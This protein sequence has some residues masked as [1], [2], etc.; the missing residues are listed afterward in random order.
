MPA[1]AQSAGAA[2]W[3]SAAGGAEGPGQPR[4]RAGPSP[5]PELPPRPPQGMG[6][7]APRPRP[8]ESSPEQVSAGGAR[9]VSGRCPP[10]ALPPQGS[11]SILS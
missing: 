11:A 6:A 2:G 4:G 8:H 10:A 1:H 7:A 3:R 5:G 9:A